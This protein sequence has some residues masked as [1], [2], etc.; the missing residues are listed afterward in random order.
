MFYF[1]ING[2]EDQCDLYT[3]SENEHGIS[4][5]KDPHS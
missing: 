4:F 5:K 3:I 2:F 1:V